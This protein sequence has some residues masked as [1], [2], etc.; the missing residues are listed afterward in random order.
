[1]CKILKL[2]YLKKSND[3]F[4]LYIIYKY[5]L[6]KIMFCTYLIVSVIIIM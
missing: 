4:S 6:C 2:S 1:M 5:K 3:F